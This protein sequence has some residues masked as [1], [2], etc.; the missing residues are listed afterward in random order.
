M[1]EAL[2]DPSPFI[3][4]SALRDYGPAARKA[5][6]RLLALLSEIAS[7]RYLGRRKED[8]LYD[9]VVDT[10]TAIAPEETA[11]RRLYSE[12]GVLKSS[13]KE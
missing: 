4:L 10:L 12:P 8:S 5:V 13:S 6:P 9:A 7:H 2:D 11:K 3:P 1:I